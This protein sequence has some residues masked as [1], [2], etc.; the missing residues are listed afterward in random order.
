MRLKDWQRHIRRIYHRRDSK[1][2]IAGNF[3]WLVE[4]IGELSRAIRWGTK[5]E[6][7]EEFADCLA[8]LASVANLSGVDL[9]RAIGK[10]RKGCPACRATPCACVGRIR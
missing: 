4:E 7:E 6:K 3:L 10:Y 5:K 1:R 9:E 8:W 2:G